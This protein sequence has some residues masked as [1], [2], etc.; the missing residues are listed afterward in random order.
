M[1]RVSEDRAHNRLKP[2]PGADF[3]HKSIAFLPANAPVISR[4]EIAEPADSR[5]KNGLWSS[6]R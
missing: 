5:R 4:Y 6:I 3:S 2:W 1:R